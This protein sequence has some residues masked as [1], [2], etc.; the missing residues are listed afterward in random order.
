MQLKV[1]KYVASLPGVLEKNTIY[2]VKNGAGFDMYVTNDTG[3]VV[4]FPLNSTKEDTGITVDGSWTVLTTWIKWYKR[5]PFSGVIT[6]WTI[7][8][9]VSGSI[10]MNVRKSNYA[11][12]PT[13]ANIAWTEKPTLSS[14]IKNQDVSLGT[15]TTDISEGDIL[16][17][18][19]ESVATIK[20]VHLFIHITPN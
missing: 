12:W 18:S 19:I 11:S 16:E 2:Y 8:G 15:W 9:D 1:E 17:Y 4:A 3:T 5:I 14:A 7:L 13:M 20:R 6:G 10:V